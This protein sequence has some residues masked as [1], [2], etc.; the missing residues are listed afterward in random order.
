MET[1]DIVALDF[2]FRRVQNTCEDV[3]H[4]ADACG[5]KRIVFGEGGE[6]INHPS[7]IRTPPNFSLVTIVF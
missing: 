2:C 6:K 7:N 5:L 1:Y 3:C 4:V